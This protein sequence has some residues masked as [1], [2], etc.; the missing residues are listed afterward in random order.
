MATVGNICDALGVSATAAMPQEVVDENSDDDGG[1]GLM[2]DDDLSKLPS[3]NLKP[4]KPPPDA[5]K[6]GCD[7]SIRD[8]FREYTAKANKDFCELTADSKAGIAL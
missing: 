3:Y 5:K 8:D 7:T 2:L 1:F 6:V 4:S